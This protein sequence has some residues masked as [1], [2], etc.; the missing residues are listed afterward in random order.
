[1]LLRP[2]AGLFLILAGCSSGQS[3]TSTPQ[4]ALPLT[5][6]IVDAAD[7][8]D[9][10][11]EKQL[12]AKLAFAETHYGPQMVVV[13]TPS[14]NGRSIEDYS[15]DLGRNWGIGDARRDDGLLLVVAPNERQVR[16]EVGYGLEGSFSDAFSKKIL[17]ETILP[18]FGAG[19]LQSGIVAGVDRMIQK[20]K[21]VPTLQAND[22][23]TPEAEDKAV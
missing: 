6:R 11:T 19:D 13:T 16:I 3:E 14:L 1:M 22:N 2:L 12:A 15:L 18:K 9:A 5:G 23:E 10:E 4:A 17:D 21:A 7:V 20:M 8:L